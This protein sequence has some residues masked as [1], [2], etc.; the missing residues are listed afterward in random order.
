[1][2]HATYFAN[3]QIEGV[4]TPRFATGL[5]FKI[6]AAALI[7]S[8]LL[9]LLGERGGNRTHD[10]LIKSQMLYLLSYALA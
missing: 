1:M 2:A 9:I 8:K 6:I 10:P 5:P 3:P 4:T 7:E